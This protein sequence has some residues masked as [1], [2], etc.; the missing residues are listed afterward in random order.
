MSR[1]RLTYGKRL[2]STKSVDNPN[3]TGKLDISCSP[4]RG[5]VPRTTEISVKRFGRKLKNVEIYSLM[6]GRDSKSVDN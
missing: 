5:S 2:M 1:K 6:F 3:I 4:T